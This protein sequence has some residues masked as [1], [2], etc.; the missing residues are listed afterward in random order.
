MALPRYLAMT[1]SEIK[2]CAQLPPKIAWMACH[3]SPYGTGLSSLP[4]SLPDGSLLILNDRTPIRGHDPVRIAQELTQCVKRFECFGVLL[5]LQR[6]GVPETEALVAHLAGALPCPMVVSSC[7]AAFCGCPVLVSCPPPHVPLKEHLQPWQGRALWMEL[8][9]EQETLR[10]T[11]DG[12]AITP[13]AS[14]E[15]Q[16]FREDSL[17]CHYSIQTAPEEAVFSLWRTGEDL[18]RLMKQAEAFGIQAVVGLYQELF[19][20]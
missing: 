6:P 17:C 19:V 14:P 20:P 1:A 18:Q 8:A 12:C 3:F 13:G 5:D 15:G 10:L 2:E 7:Y 16:A 9:L 11:A 4:P